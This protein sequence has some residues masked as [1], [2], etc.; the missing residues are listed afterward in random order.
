MNTYWISNNETHDW[1]CI[2]TNQYMDEEAINNYCRAHYMG[3]W[4]GNFTLEVAEEEHSTSVA[5]PEFLCL[6]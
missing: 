5:Q 3:S 6:A 2:Q 4:V 1:D